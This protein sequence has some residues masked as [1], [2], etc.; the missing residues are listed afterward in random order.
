MGGRH[1]STHPVSFLH[2]DIPISF[3][4]LCTALPS[5]SAAGSLDPVGDG[6]ST[7]SSTTVVLFFQPGVF[8]SVLYDTVVLLG[9]QHNA[10]SK[11]SLSEGNAPNR[12]LIL[13]KN[14]VERTRQQEC[15]HQENW[16]GSILRPKAQEGPATSSRVFTTGPTLA[17]VFGTR[18]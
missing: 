8:F 13:N 18:F 3:V 12:V 7:V 17:E 6:V 9:P 2:P 11:I 15:P 16:F 10:T 5:P 4:P 14:L 1:C